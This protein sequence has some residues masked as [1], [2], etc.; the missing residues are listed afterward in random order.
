MKIVYQSTNYR[1][2]LVTGKYV[3][4]IGKKPNYKF[5]VFECAVGTGRFAGRAG[6]GPTLREYDCDGSDLPSDVVELA[7]QTKQTVRLD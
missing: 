1:P 2:E 4:C 3:R 7:I 5:R 6:F